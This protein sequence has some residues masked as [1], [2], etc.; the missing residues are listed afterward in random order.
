MYCTELTF[1]YRNAS[2]KGSPRIRLSSNF[3]DSCP[4]VSISHVW[5]FCCKIHSISVSFKLYVEGLEWQKKP[6][7]CG[8]VQFR[9]I[10]RCSKVDN[11]NW[12]GRSAWVFGGGEKNHQNVDRYLHLYTV[13]SISNNF[14]GPLDISI[15]SSLIFSLY[16][17]PPYLE[18]LSVS[19]KNFGP[20][21]IF[22]SLS[23]TFQPSH[24]L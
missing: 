19:N 9:K 6:Q 22:L 18:L 10:G 7:I 5:Y 17:E 2:I 8:S 3:N 21:Q 13:D 24:S 1:A 14:L 15:D 12:V 20:M 4:A 23:R 16:L 11:K